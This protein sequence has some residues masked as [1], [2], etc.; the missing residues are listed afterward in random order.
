MNYKYT[1]KYFSTND[2]FMPFVMVFVSHCCW[3][4]WWSTARGSEFHWKEIT[5]L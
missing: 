5:D 1:Q 2:L 3:G 4:I